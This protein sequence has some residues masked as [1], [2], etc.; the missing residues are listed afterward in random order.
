MNDYPTLSINICK[1]N[2]IDELV[3]NKKWRL[4]K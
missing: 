3:N 4:E 1:T 2:Y